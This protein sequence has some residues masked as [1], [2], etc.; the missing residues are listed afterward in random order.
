MTQ[1]ATP[2]QPG[3]TSSFTVRFAPAASGVRQATLSIENDSDRNPFD[4]AVGGMGAAMAMRIIEIKP[5]SASGSIILQWSGDGPQ[6]QVEKATT[7]LG[8]FQPLGA[9]QSG[10]ILTGPPLV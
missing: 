6:F 3:G 9:P 10:R 7:I 4:F 1:P 5:D 8:A 2:I